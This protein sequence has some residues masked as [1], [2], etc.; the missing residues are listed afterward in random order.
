MIPGPNM[1]EYVSIQYI[2]LEK[3]GE[4]EGGTERLRLRLQER[5]GSQIKKQNT[6]RNFFQWLYNELVYE[7]SASKS[8]PISFV[9]EPSSASLKQNCEIGT[10][11]YSHQLFT[12][13]SAFWNPIS[14]SSRCA[15]V[16]ASPA[17]PPGIWFFFSSALATLQMWLI[18]VQGEEESRLSG[19]NS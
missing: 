15:V 17:P 9:L 10:V 7:S 18:S 14:L 13:C 5:K 3:E 12:S 16:S 19:I 2:G 6:G 11:C 1:R 4:R 8:E